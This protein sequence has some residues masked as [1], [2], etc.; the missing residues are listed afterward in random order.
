MKIGMITDSLPEASFDEMLDTAAELEMDM[1]EFACGNWSGAIPT[2]VSRTRIT[3]SPSTDSATKSIRPPG[4]LVR[5]V[6]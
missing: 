6:A 4:S 5:L 3:A 1:L 2:P